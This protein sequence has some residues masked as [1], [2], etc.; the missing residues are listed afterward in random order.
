MAIYVTTCTQLNI[1]HQS[2]VLHRESSLVALKHKVLYY[3]PEQ[4]FF[5]SLFKEMNHTSGIISKTGS[6]ITHIKDIINI[7]LQY[8]EGGANEKLSSLHNG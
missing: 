1:P 7:I 3:L 6:K 2:L 8:M 5:V 4:S